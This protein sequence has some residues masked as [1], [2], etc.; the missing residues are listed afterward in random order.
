[1]LRDGFWLSARKKFRG[2]SID[3]FFKTIGY[4]FCCFFY[5]FSENFRG[6][7]VVLGG[8]GAPCSR[9]PGFQTCE[10]FGSE[11]GGHGRTLCILRSTGIER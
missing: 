1:M 3:H 4:C 5:C 9:K 7:K 10:P 6:A 8:G 2:D 11:G